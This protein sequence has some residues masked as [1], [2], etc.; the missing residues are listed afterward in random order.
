MFIMLNYFSV[1]ITGTPKKKEK[2]VLII[3]NDVI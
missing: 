3:E 2:A 1:I